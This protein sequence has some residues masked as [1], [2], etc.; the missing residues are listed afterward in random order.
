MNK[1]TIERVMMPR[2]RASVEVMRSWQN[3]N[4]DSTCAPCNGGNPAC[5]CEYGHTITKIFGSKRGA[6]RWIAKNVFYDEKDIAYIADNDKQK[7]IKKAWLLHGINHTAE[8]LGFKKPYSFDLKCPACG[9]E[10]FF[11]ECDTESSE[12]G[13]DYYVPE[14]REKTKGCC[15]NEELELLR[16]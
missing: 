14:E 6:E 15:N 12:N 16:R 4:Y 7:N 8:L 5:E 11:I 10:Y 2:Y 1:F 3:C 9:K 13:Y